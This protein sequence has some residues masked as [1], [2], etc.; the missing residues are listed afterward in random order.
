MP[1]SNKYTA[2]L[3]VANGYIKDFYNPFMKLDVS[4]SSSADTI[5]MKTS[6]YKIF[7]IAQFISKDNFWKAMIEEIFINQQRRH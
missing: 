7:R 1:T 2:S 6:I 4:D 5:T 3:I